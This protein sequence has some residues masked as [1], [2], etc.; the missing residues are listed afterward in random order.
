VSRTWTNA[1][2]FAV[3]ALLGL[4]AC[5]VAWWPQT[6]QGSVEPP[7]QRVLA[8]AAPTQNTPPTK[9][10][11]ATIAPTQAPTATIAPNPP[12]P[13]PAAPT[14]K[15]THKPTHSGGSTGGNSTGGN[16]ASGGTSHHTPTT[17][18]NSGGSN[19]SSGSS[20]GGGGNA[21]STHSTTGSTGST[22]SSGSSGST[23]TPPP[24]G[25]PTNT[26]AH[27]PSSHPTTSA[28][29]PTGAPTSRS[30][31]AVVATDP[32]SAATDTVGGRGDKVKDDTGAATDGSDT[33]DT[34]L[35]S[36]EPVET[37][38]APVWVVPGILLV[39]TSMLALLG[40]VLGRGNRPA[41]ARV[42]VSDD[43]PGRDDS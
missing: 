5:L 33:Y 26:P 14:H 7:A 20:S 15:P 12:A 41:L 1:V 38:S 24:A 4:A 3:A 9:T 23:Y 29:A 39:L 42:T 25:S 6:A 28:S 31:D 2:R 11:T 19:H 27:T 8:A 30:T 34:Y 43:P 17:L 13:P 10:P 22:G 18:H 16:H 37:T 35:T 32:T 21:P 36:S 40:G